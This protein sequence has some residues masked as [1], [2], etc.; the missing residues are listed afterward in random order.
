V[1]RHGDQQEFVTPVAGAIFR[2]RRQHESLAQWQTERVGWDKKMNLRT[3][4][5]N[6]AHKMRCSRFWREQSV[7]E[8]PRMFGGIARAARFSYLR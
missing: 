8:A 1:Q 2:Q 3:L 7:A 6:L 5:L 4:A